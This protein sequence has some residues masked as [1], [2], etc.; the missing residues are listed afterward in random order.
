MFENNAKVL[1]DSRIRLGLRN[2]LQRE[3]F[4]LLNIENDVEAIGK[5]SPAVHDIIDNPDHVEIRQLINEGKFKEA[6]RIIAEQIG[7]I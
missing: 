3:L 1:E 7:V 6:A 2:R 4:S 5:L